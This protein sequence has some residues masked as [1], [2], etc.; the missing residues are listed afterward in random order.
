MGAL[1][2]V[3]TYVAMVTRAAR[4]RA[5]DEACAAT[6][7]ELCGHLR[8][9]HLELPYVVRVGSD[10]KLEK[11]D[12]PDYKPFHFHCRHVGCSCVRVPS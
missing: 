9:D 5:L 11:V 8:S 3:L 1:R 2:S 10:G 4:Q 6:K 7:C 12:H